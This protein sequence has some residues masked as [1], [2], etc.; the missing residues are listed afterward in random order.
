MR[1]AQF[2]ERVTVKYLTDRMGYLQHAIQMELEGKSSKLD[3]LPAED[4]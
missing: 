1:Y 3:E 4:W 2:V